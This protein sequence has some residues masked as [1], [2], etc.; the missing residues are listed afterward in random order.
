MPNIMTSIISHPSAWYGKD[1][2]RD[3]S[4]IVQLD[5]RQLDEIAAA[6]AVAKSRGVPHEFT[7]QVG[8]PAADPGHSAA[9]LAEGRHRRPR[10]LPAARPERAGLHR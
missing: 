2:A 5:R 8:L 9:H 3:T 1:L 6:L 7:G 4:W 10:L